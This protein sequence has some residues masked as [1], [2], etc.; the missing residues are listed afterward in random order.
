MRRITMMLAVALTV[1]LFRPVAAQFDFG[2]LGS[3]ND[4]NL[5]GQLLGQPNIGDTPRLSFGLGLIAVAKVYDRFSLQVAPGLLEKG[6]ENGSPGEESIEVRLSY[7][8]IPVNLKISMGKP[9]L[10]LGGYYSYLISASYT[11]GFKASSEGVSDNFSDDDSGLD[12]AV[13]V[14][15]GVKNSGT[16]FVV[17][18]HWTRGFSEL[19]KTPIQPGDTLEHRGFHLKFGVVF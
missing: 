12:I 6:G 13:G 16:G 7:I 14:D 17:E 18:L 10:L 19:V 3:A 2:V 15:L 1:I 9:Y 5:K 4:C 11:E 8:D